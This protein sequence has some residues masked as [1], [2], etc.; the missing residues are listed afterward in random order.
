MDADPTPEACILCEVARVLVKREKAVRL[1]FENGGV[2]QK[3]E[4]TKLMSVLQDT[5]AHRV[6]ARQAALSGGA[7]RSQLQLLITD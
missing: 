2:P 6:V 1:A 7:H 4:P 3:V 5:C